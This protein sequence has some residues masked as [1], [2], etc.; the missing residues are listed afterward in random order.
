[1]CVR[2]FCRALVD[3][4]SVELLVTVGEQ[5]HQ[6]VDPRPEQRVLKVDP[7][8]LDLPV[9]RGDH[10][11]VAA[12]VIAV[13]EAARPGGD[14]GRQPVGDLLERGAIGAGQWRC[15]APTMPHSKK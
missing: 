15:R 14:P 11:Q 12:L 4:R 5:R 9:C 6:V 2:V 1:M 13:D 7:R 3:E 8:E 10:H